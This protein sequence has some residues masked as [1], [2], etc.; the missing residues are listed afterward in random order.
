METKIVE[1]W[2]VQN[3]GYSAGVSWFVTRAPGREP[4]RFESE[5]TARKFY[6][7]NHWG[8]KDV[9]WRLVHVHIASTPDQR[10]T[11]ERFI[12]LRAPRGARQ[13]D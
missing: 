12:K 5:T 6:R 11:T 7:A 10:V 13:R 3:T 9:K 1:Y 2:I 4:E 8:D